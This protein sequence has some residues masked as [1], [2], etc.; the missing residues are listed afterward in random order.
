MKIKIKKLTDNAVIPHKAHPT[1]AGFDLTAT[2]C[3]MDEYG[4]MV[5]GTGIAVEIPEGYVGLVFPRSS[6]CKKD[7]MLTNSV[8]VIDSGFRGEIMAKFKPTNSF[9]YYDDFGLIS[10]SLIK[11]N[12]YEI[13]ERIAQ[14]IIMPIPQIEFVEADELSDSDRGEGGFGSSGK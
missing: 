3:T 11:N 14:L 10:E 5:Y 6:I 1:D 2:S 12:W 8:G 9:N 13:G 4:S 7:I